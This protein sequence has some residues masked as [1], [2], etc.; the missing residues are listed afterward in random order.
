MSASQDHRTGARACLCGA[1]LAS[2]AARARAAA[3]ASA[4][5]ARAPGD[6]RGGDRHP[7]EAAQGLL[8]GA[9]PRD[10]LARARARVRRRRGPERRFAGRPADAVPLRRP[11]A[12]RGG[13]QARSI[14]EKAAGRRPAALADPGVLRAPRRGLQGAG[15]GEDPRRSPTCSPGWSPTCTPARPDRQLRRPEDR[16]ARPLGAL[17]R[18]SCRRPWASDLKLVARRRR[19]LDNPKEYVF[20][21]ITRP[22]SGSTTSS[23]STSSR[24]RG[25][26]GYGELYFEDLARRVGPILRSSVLSRGG[27]GRRAATGTRPGRW[28]DVPSSSELAAR[29]DGRAV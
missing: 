9:P 7:A 2:A 17:R 20:S 5:R 19:Y 23:T 24:T 10:A 3:P 25:K 27:R 8:Q 14:G 21:M 22:T 29:V 16:P 4:C 26:P 15:Q 11:A 6:G 12:H 13:A 28:R 18:R 1:A